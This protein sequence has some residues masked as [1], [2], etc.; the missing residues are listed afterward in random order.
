MTRIAIINSSSFGHVFPEHLKEFKKFAEVEALKVD[1]AISASELATKLKNFDGILASTNPNYSANLLKQLPKLKIIARHGI[2]FNNIDIDTAQELGIIVTKVLGPVER[3]SV[4]EH[5]LALL[6]SAARWTPQ[7]DLA[8]KES[9]W[10]IRANFVG[11]EVTGKTIGII[12]LGNI[13]SRSAEILA[14][15][16]NAK[17]LVNDPN[18]SSTELEA[19]GYEV[20]T[21]EQLLKQSDFICLHCAHTTETHHLLGREQLQLCLLY[22]SD[23][24]DE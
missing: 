3:N 11:K 21:L 17:I 8:V 1:T 5:N 13:G 15:G 7:A 10:K 6:M 16:F 24:A 14:K 9:N 22:T 23:A 18:K 4:A 19:S 20:A 12:G 2:G